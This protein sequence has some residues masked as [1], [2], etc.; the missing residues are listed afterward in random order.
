MSADERDDAERIERER[1]IA[2][3]RG[4]AACCYGCGEHGTRRHRVLQRD[5]G[6]ALKWHL[7]C[8]R[9]AQR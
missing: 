6:S 4:F 2:A 9:A 3:T 8:Y 1:I 7:S 5:L